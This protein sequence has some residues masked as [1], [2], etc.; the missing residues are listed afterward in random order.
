MSFMEAVASGKRMKLVY[1][2]F[3]NQIYRDLGDLLFNLS[4]ECKTDIARDIIINGK[5]HI[6]D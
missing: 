2:P 6:E 4:K 1:E 3:G 5:F